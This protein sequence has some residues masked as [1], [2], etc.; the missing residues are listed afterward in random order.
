[1]TIQFDRPIGAHRDVKELQYLSAL[2]QTGQTLRQDAT[3]TGEFFALYTVSI[4]NWILEDVEPNELCIQFELTPILPCLLC[5]AEDV[6]H[7]LMSRHG[8]QADMDFVKEHLMPGLAGAL[9]DSS[10]AVFDIVEIVSILLIPY[11]K[12]E[13]EEYVASKDNPP[14]NIFGKVL[15]MILKDASTTESVDE[16]PFL[17]RAMMQN[18]LEAYGEF[19]VPP[20]VIDEMLVA[21]GA[22]LGEDPARLDAEMLMKACTSDIVHYNSQWDKSATTH[23]Y[24]VFHGTTLDADEEDAPSAP[25]GFRGNIKHTISKDL[26]DEEVAKSKFDGGSCVKRVYTAPSIDGIAE[27]YNSK[28]FVTVLWLLIVVIYFTYILGLTSVAGVECERL[29]SE[30]SCKVVNA[31]VTWLLVFVQLR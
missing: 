3:V 28:T 17:D 12:N 1:M 11:L 19:G 14:A 29:K 22:P 23:Y 27:N 5:A 31:I 16:K 9:G 18:I 20:E 10:V 30:F 8:I 15:G 26:A 6:I 2:H 7:F 24:D 25:T 4:A 13:G 21:A